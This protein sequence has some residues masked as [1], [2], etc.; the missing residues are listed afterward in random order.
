MAVVEGGGC[1]M[2]MVREKKKI[3]VRV[4]DIMEKRR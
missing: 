2:V 1:G 4:S 3:R